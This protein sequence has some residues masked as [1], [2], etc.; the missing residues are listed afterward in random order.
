MSGK[1]KNDDT[2]FDYSNSNQSRE[3]MTSF[4]PQDENITRIYN[5]LQVLTTSCSVR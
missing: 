3:L 5:L 1:I 4:S 2:H